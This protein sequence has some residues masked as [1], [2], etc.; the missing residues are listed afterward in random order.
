[1][2]AYYLCC[3]SPSMTH[4]LIMYHYSSLQ[5]GTYPAT[6]HLHSSSHI[7]TVSQSVMLSTCRLLHGVAIQGSH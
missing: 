5:D 3:D 6:L 2:L 1:M 7:S 4:I